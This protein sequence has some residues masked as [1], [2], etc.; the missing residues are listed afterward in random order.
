[1]SSPLSPRGVSGGDGGWVC[2]IVKPG[3]P[4]GAVP[5]V[6]DVFTLVAPRGFG[7]GWWVTSM[8]VG[9]VWWARRRVFS[10]VYRSLV[11]V[12]LCAG[13]EGQ[14]QESRAGGVTV[15]RV[16]DTGAC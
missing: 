12:L 16:E 13:G 10:A 3:I 14:G 2:I 11:G 6:L 15:G 4:E 5:R 8:G 7:W 1:M 9:C